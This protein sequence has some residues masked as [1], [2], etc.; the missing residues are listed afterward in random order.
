MK[1]LHL[2]AYDPA[3]FPADFW[4]SADCEILVMD[5]WA[6]EHAGEVEALQKNLPD[7]AA[8]V[9]IASSGTLAVPGQSKWIALSKTALLASGDG[10]NAHIGARKT[11]TW[12]LVLPLAHVGGLGILAR[13]HLLGNK[14][15]QLL[16]EKWRPEAL[17]RD[18]WQGELLSLVPTQLHDLV[19]NNIRPPQTLRSVIIG[20]DRLDSGLAE[21][22][23]LAGWPVLASYG[24][25]ECGSQIA[26][27]TGLHPDALTLLPH[28]TAEI[29]ED[30]NLSLQSSAL[31]TGI[32]SVENDRWSYVERTSDRWTA[33]D[34]VKLDG[35]MLKV[36]GRADSIV[37]IR[38]EKVDIPY[39][40]DLL[41]RKAGAS[42]VI[43]T[44]PDPRDGQALWSVSEGKAPDLSGLHSHQIPRG[45][46][47]IKSFPRSPLGKIKRGE[48]KE[49]VLN[50]LSQRPPLE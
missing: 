46:I 12:G 47:T 31:F 32:C 25:T 30:G 43:I 36:I 45:H 33:P 6:K 20:G 50:S 17:S 10:V 21:K 39:I 18:E 7:I 19:E 26:T 11:D 2:L 37:K 48:V 9:W 13:A 44:L 35:K 49:W 27:G 22:A 42:V 23:R 40:E 15:V 3:T 29:D 4:Q 5:R 38:G 41:S 28:I 34:L 14:V 8:H 16:S 1:R 24:M